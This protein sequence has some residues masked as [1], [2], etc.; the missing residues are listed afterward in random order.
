MKDRLSK[1]QRKYWIIGGVVLVAAIAVGAYFF[2]RPT[3]NR[4]AF[5]TVQVQEGPLQV[6]VGSTGSVRAKQSATLYWGTS[7]TV[8]TVNAQIGDKVTA[9]EILATLA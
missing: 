9:N 5:Q 8:D 2:T 6:T 4:Q 3:R 7:G 1:I